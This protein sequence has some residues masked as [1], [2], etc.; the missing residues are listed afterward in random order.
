MGQIKAMFEWF[1]YIVLC[2][3]IMSKKRILHC[4]VKINMKKKLFASILGSVILTFYQ[5]P[6][7]DFSL[8]AKNHFSSVNVTLRNMLICRNVTLK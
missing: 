4:S 5:L 7:Y 1:H 2:N 8:I 3:W 6:F